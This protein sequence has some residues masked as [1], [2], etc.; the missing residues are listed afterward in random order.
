MVYNEKNDME[1][2]ENFAEQDEKK[3]VMY[4]VDTG[5]SEHRYTSVSPT[6]NKRYDDDDFW[7]LGEVRRKVYHKP[8]FA[9]TAV[10]N[11]IVTHDISTEAPVKREKI[12]SPPEKVPGEP[13]RYQRTADNTSPHGSRQIPTSRYSSSRPAA[14]TV[15]NRQNEAL[16][17]MKTVKEYDCSGLLIRHVEIKPW[18]ASIP[19]YGRFAAE[20]ALFHEKEG[21]PCEAVEFFAYVPQYSKMNDKQQQFY[22]YVRDSIRQGT[23][24]RADLSY[25][26]LYIYEIINL[27][28]LIPPEKGASLLADIWLH[29]REWYPR[30]DVFLSEWLSNY[31]LIHQ[32]PLPSALTPIL[33]QIVKKAQF[34]EF[35]LD[36]FSDGDMPSLAEA[37]MEFSSDYDYRR[38]RYYKGHEKDY[39]EK[40]PAAVSEAL[41]AA[42]RE[43]RG[44]FAFEKKYRLT[45]DAYC[46]AVVPAEIKRRIDVEFY[47]FTR[48]I[49]TR[50][51][52]TELVKYAENKLRLALKIKAKLAVN[53]ISSAD[54]NVIDR[55]F[56]PMIPE[57]APSKAASAAAAEAEYLK[58]YEADSSGFDF[59][60]AEQIE[61]SS[62]DNTNM[63][64]AAEED[65]AAEKD[66]Q[67]EIPV[68]PASL[69]DSHSTVEKEDTS[70]E[71]TAEKEGLLAAMDGT[72]RK[73][74]RDNGFFDS[75][76]A[77]KI[78]EIFLDILGDIVLE[79]SDGEYKLIEDYREDVLEWLN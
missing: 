56:A 33:P 49:E 39:E 3:T 51:I 75:D 7:N 12:P 1:N 22:L 10:E 32:V 62:W 28:N 4:T 23:Y 11:T 67:S 77:S 63:L 53:D 5:S 9:D 74:C 58:L 24:I 34:K 52:V 38:S 16:R 29:Y 44:I 17:N 55:F 30:I 70:S 41:T 54:C 14:V 8:T 35:Y 48:P 61:Q 6:K 36:V 15:Q 25:I 60:A 42:Y 65:R 31:C 68:P 72:F 21:A 43:K 20:A 46:G 69:S 76:M 37:L 64:T 78:N 73:Y 26:L 57:K 19:F 79:E 27:P 2:T 50:K 59:T 13:F 71:N 66:T 45:I 47:S 40:L 18:A